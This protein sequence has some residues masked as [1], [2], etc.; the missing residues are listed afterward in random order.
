MSTAWPG[1]LATCSTL[2]VGDWAVTVVDRGSDG[3]TW[4]LAPGGDGWERLDAF[5]QHLLRPG[6]H[7]AVGARVLTYLG[8]WPA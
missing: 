3:G 7:V 2:R 6:S 8:A 1:S 4:V 5:R